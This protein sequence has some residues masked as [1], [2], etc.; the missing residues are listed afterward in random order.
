[1]IIRKEIKILDLL[2]LVP[3]ER[4]YRRVEIEKQ[5]SR[6]SCSSPGAPVYGLKCSKGGWVGSIKET[7][8]GMTVHLISSPVDVEGIYP[9]P[10]KCGKGSTSLF[11]RSGVDFFPGMAS[12]EFSS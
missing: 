2:S 4:F 8:E 7:K 10:L 3:L 9:K 11:A 5:D 6:K 1:V 12:K